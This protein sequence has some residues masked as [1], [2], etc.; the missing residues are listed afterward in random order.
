MRFLP[1][2]V[3]MPEQRKDEVKSREGCERFQERV[4][5]HFRYE[6]TA[7]RGEKVA[8]QNMEVEE[9]KV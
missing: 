1:D 2:S 9:S 6:L 5:K 7:T 8:C 4:V 3:V